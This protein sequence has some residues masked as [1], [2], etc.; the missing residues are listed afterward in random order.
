MPTKN[1]SRRVYRFVFD[2]CCMLDTIGP[3]Q[4][5]HE[6]NEYSDTDRYET[7]LISLAGGSIVTDMGVLLE[8]QSAHQI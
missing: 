8:T 5:F 3:L 6:A 2:G 4:V 7:Q 1:A